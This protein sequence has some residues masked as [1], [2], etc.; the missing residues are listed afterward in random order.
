M[1]VDPLSSAW[2]K[3]HWASKHME[4]V[5]RALAKSLHPDADPISIKLDHEE[6]LASAVWVAKIEKLRGLRADIG[7]ALGDVL[8]NFRAS[9]DHVAWAL[10]RLGADPRPKRPDFVYFPMARSGKSF[11]DN[12]DRWLPGVSDED[13]TIIRRYQPYRRGDRAKAMRWLRNFST[14]DKHRVLVPTVVNQSEINLRVTANW[15]IA[16][17][18][19][20]VRERRALNVGTPVLKVTC[21]R[22]GPANC[23]VEVEGEVSLYPS[24]GY[25]VPVDQTLGMIRAT[26]LEIL[27]IFEERF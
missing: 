21:V 9:L 23:H 10:V 15:P 25:G 7:L 17:L 20:L 6:R 12:I 2:A 3:Y 1:P 19:K 13:R 27:T 4:S 16:G 18:D 11:G 26:I 22:A 14:V 8:Q 5:Q 24:L